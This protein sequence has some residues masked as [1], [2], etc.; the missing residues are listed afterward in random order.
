M[1]LGYNWFVEE[2]YMHKLYIIKGTSRG[3]GNELAKVLLKSSV[4]KVIGLSRSASQIRDKSFT[5]IIHDLSRSRLPHIHIESTFSTKYISK[6]DSITLVNNAGIIEPIKSI[7]ESSLRQIEDAININL[8]SLIY[9]SR[10]FIKHTQNLKCKKIICNMTSGAADR[11]CA[12]ITMYNTTKA[13]A[14]MFTR[15]I[16]LEQ[17]DQEYPVTVVGFRPGRVRTSLMDKAIN[18][19]EKDFPNT[20]TFRKNKENNEILEPSLVAKTLVDLLNNQEL[21]SGHIYHIRQLLG[22]REPFNLDDHLIS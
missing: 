12:G 2:L 9:L 16:A 5:E 15:S 11:P 18:A 8:R 13:A 4:N 6:F 10:L 20:I 22:I 7:S 14:E 21:E 19:S 3:L 1:R 17:V